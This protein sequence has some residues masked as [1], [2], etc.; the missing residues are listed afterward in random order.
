MGSHD[1]TTFGALQEAIDRN[2]LLEKDIEY[3]RTTL[4]AVCTER[5]DFRSLAGRLQIQVDALRKQ[6]DYWRERAESSAAELV[7]RDRGEATAMQ[8]MQ[9]L[10][11][12][13]GRYVL[14]DQHDPDSKL[15][16]V[17]APNANELRRLL[18]EDI[19]RI[20]EAKVAA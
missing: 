18:V 14:C 20:R 7:R 3:Y 5:D 15:T 9:Y 17:Y 8:V 6:A 2:A 1:S 10:R 19:L 12:G 16:P 13:A 11:D 4:A